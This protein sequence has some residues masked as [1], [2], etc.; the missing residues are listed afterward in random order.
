[1]KTFKLEIMVFD[2]VTGQDVENIISDAKRD[3]MVYNVE[4]LPKDE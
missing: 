4:L 2:C 1:M 3:K